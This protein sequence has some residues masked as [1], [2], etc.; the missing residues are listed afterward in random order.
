MG[1]SDSKDDSKSSF[2]LRPHCCRK[3]FEFYDKLM[4]VGTNNDTKRKMAVL[5]NLDIF[6]LDNS[7]R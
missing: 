2:A 5:K 1:C 4:C 3:D 6:V 7:I